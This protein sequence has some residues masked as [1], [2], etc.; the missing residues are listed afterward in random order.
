LRKETFL[1]LL[2]LALLV[3]SPLA[4]ADAPAP[5]VGT[6]HAVQPADG[7]ETG[8]TLAELD[9]GTPEPLA[10]SG[11]TAEL[12]CPTDGTVITC[13]G[14]WQCYRA[15]VSVVCDSHVTYCPGLFG[16]GPGGGGPIPQQ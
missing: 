9:L 8:V 3:A 6:D 2:L 16:G 11:C 12:T 7:A 5:A 14:S 1:R 4:L 10:M 13:S 15:N